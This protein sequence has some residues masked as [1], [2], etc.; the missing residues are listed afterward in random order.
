MTSFVYLFV[1]RFNVPVNNF[2][3][4]SGWSHRFL[5]FISFRGVKC[6]AQGH[7]PVKIGFEP[8]I[9]RSGVRRSNTEPLHFSFDREI[10]TN[11]ILKE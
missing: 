6:L 11:Y 1:L 9:S 3:V 2:S 7:N 4:V 5:S 10:H 8:P